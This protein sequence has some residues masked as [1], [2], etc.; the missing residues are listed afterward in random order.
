MKKTL[1]ILLCLFA[2]IFVLADC[3]NNSHS[4]SSSRS[5]LSSSSSS[6]SS[7]TTKTKAKNVLVVYFSGSGNTE[8][9]AKRI[10]KTA[11]ADLFEVTPADPY[12]S[13]DLDW[14]NDNSRVV[15]EHNSTSLQNVK[16]K[17]TTVK[18]WSKY[19]T[20]FIGYPIW[21]GE[22]AWPMNS[23]VKAGSFSGKTVI[24]FCTS[25]SSGLGS[26]ATD[27][28]SLAKSRG[29]WKTGQRFEESSSNSEIDRFVN[30]NISK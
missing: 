11:G 30:D 9:V 28:A 5:T 7:S 3:S 25:S 20:V 10:A 4:T 14:T 22:A 21:W 19:D 1:K 24:P 29:T 12:T 2:A 23:F 26:S 13:D 6:A 8:K 15:K 27:L 17:T 18:N 16:L